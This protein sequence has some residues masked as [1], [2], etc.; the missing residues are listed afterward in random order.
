MS[1]IS[2]VPEFDN[3]YIIR[4]LLFKYRL[5]FLLVFLYLIHLKARQIQED[6]KNISQYFKGRNLI[7]YNYC[8]IMSKNVDI[9]LSE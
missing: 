7:M 3:K 8:Q 1:N 9:D 4:F 6:S 2:V 5:I